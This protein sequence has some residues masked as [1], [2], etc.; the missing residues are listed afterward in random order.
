MDATKI[1][2]LLL[3]N[4]PILLAIAGGLGLLGAVAALVR[5]TVVKARKAAAASPNKIDDVLVDLIDGPI[6]ELADLIETGN[7]PAAKA[8]VTAIKALTD[9]AKKGQSLN[10]PKLPARKVDPR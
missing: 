8:K 1:L 5:R 4:L 3:A 7:I 10:L 6:L 9:A 2:E